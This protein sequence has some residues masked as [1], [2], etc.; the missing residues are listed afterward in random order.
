MV[1]DP[2]GQKKPKFF[3]MI[4]KHSVKSIDIILYVK[5]VKRHLHGKKLIL[6]WDGLTA[7]TSRETKTYITTQSSWLTVERLPT[8]APELNPPEHAWAAMKAKDMGNI[9]ATST[10]DLD[11]H[12]HRSIRRIKRSCT[13]LRGCL[14]ASGLFSSFD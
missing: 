6:F 13:I 2:K 9:E 7:H 10:E 8:Y 11:R 12:I 1:T 3:A 5:Y 14:R 4:R